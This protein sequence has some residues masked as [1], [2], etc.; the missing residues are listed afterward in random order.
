MFRMLN[1]IAVL[2]ALLAIAAAPV[3]ASITHN[4]ITHNAI[5][6]N[7][8]ISAGSGLADLNGVAVEAVVLPGR[9]AR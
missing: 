2:A 3:Q 4:S 6:H 9:T 7:A 1:T 8:L 5:T